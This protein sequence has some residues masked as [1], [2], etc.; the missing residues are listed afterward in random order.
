LVN[1]QEVGPPG[2]LPVDPWDH[3]GVESGCCGRMLSRVVM[4]RPDS[5]DTKAH[6]T[7]IATG[8]NTIAY[9]GPD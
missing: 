1:V 5:V 8:K 7:G 2:F 6:A 3:S 4:G 9:A